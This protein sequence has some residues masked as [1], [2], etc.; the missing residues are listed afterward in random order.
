MSNDRLQCSDWLH[1]IS[2]N[3]RHCRADDCHGF[4]WLMA[5]ASVMI[6]SMPGLAGLNAYTAFERL[7][8]WLIERKTTVDGEHSCRASI[9]SGGAWF[10]ENI[11]LDRQGKLVIP[12]GVKGHAYRGQVPQV[13]VV[14]QRCREESYQFE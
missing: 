6:V 5:A 12:S 7:G 1:Q 3:L 10:S 8:N 9:P 11:H 4:C 2:A 13:R 14:L